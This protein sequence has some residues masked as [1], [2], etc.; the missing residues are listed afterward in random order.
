MA[1]SLDAALRW[2]DQ[3]QDTHP[4]THHGEYRA[5][6]QYEGCSLAAGEAKAECREG[7]ADRL[8][9]QACGRHH[10]A[11]AAAAI[12]RCARHQGLHVRRLEKAKSTSADGHPPND[13]GDMRA[14][15]KQSNT[16]TREAEQRKT[17]AA[18]N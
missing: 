16:T 18:E 5:K 9:G 2:R 13:V 17:N 10:P 8:S 12:G 11:G 15:R 14:C 1:E 3:A 7:R 4:A 6:H